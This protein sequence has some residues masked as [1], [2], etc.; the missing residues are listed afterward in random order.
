MIY[1]AWCGPRRHSCPFDGSKSMAWTWRNVL[2]QLTETNIFNGLAPQPECQKCAKS[3]LVVH[4]ANRLAF[5]SLPPADR[6]QMSII[7]RSPQRPILFTALKLQ[8]FEMSS[9]F[10]GCTTYQSVDKPA[11]R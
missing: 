6:S 8:A 4:P 3:S 7:S 1:V 11:S 9:S 5:S 10:T 2:C